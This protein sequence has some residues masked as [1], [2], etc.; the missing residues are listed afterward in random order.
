MRKTSFETVEIVTAANPGMTV[1]VL[2]PVASSRHFSRQDTV[3]E[4]AMNR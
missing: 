1:T 3:I 2:S 4:K